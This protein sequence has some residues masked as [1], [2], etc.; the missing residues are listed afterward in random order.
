MYVSQYGTQTHWQAA[1]ESA[2]VLDDMTPLPPHPLR[3]PVKSLWGHAHM[4]MMTCLNVLR[5]TPPN[6]TDTHDHITHTQSKYQGEV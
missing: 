6:H 2:D 5:R 4:T 3:E 1:E